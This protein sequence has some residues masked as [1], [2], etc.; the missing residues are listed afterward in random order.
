MAGLLFACKGERAE[1]GRGPAAAGSDKLL[2]GAVSRHS[3]DEL[4]TNVS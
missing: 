4:D 2:V 1:A 3:L